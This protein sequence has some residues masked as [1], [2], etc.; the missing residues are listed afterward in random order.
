MKLYPYTN[1]QT[2]NLKSLLISA[3]FLALLSYILFFGAIII[4]VYGTLIDQPKT[5]NMG[6]SMQGTLS[7]PATTGPAILAAIWG[8]V[9]SISILAFS[10]LCAAVVSCEYKYTTT[11]E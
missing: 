3:R 8:V 5:F 6:G 7:A 11:V 9:S 10:G 4:G 2:K 1:I